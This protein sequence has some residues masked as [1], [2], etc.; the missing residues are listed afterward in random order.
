MY[1]F[2]QEF[3][4]TNLH[5]VSQVLTTTE[6]AQVLKRLKMLQNKIFM[7]LESYNTNLHVTRRK[8]FR[9]HSDCIA[10]WTFDL[11]FYA[12]SFNSLMSGGNKK[13][14]HT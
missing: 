7:T 14:T 5:K 9:Y 2:S 1:G 3:F 11:W 10:L 12:K 8:L 13:V 4:S 6:L